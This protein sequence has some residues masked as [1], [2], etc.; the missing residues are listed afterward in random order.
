MAITKSVRPKTVEEFIGGAPDAPRVVPPLADTPPA[1]P[2]G[3]QR[4][5]KQ[6]IT[7]TIAPH[8]LE[9]IDALAERMGQSRAALINVA[10]HR[11]IEGGL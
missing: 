4:G 8:L 10:I 6:Q 2:K 5:N 7:L 3:I 9:K 11:H 1:K